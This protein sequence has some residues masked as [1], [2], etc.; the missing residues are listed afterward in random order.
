M[1]RI[2][3]FAHYDGQAEVKPYILVFLRALTEVCQEIIFVSTAPLPGSELERV[4]PYCTRAVLSE[5]LGYDFGMWQGALESLDLADVDEL[6]LTNSSVFGPIYPLAPVLDRMTKDGCDFWGMTDSFE[7]H[8]HLQSYFLVFKKAALSSPAFAAFFKAILPYRDKDQLIRSYEIGLTQFLV[9]QGLRAAA[10]VPVASWL[11]SPKARTR[12]SRRRQNATVFQ[13]LQLITAG[14]PLVKVQLL[15][16]NPR[17]LPL[18][19][20]LRAMKDSGYQMSNVRFDRSPPPAKTLS[21]RFRR[22]IHPPLAEPRSS[23]KT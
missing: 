14:M 13:P 3:L 19:P 12:L 16:D 4:R 10:F 22:W 18:A 1:K 9:E 7:I 2:A 11:S 20:V 15:R 23:P 8:W 17:G 5:N 21:A 6:L